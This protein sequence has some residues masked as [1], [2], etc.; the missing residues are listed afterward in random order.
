MDR[1]GK[2][3]KMLQEPS[4]V[5]LNLNFVAITS[6]SN[7]LQMIMMVKRRE[8]IARMATRRAEF[9]S[10]LLHLWWQRHVRMWD[11]SW[12]LNSSS[13]R[14]MWTNRSWLTLELL[15][16]CHFHAQILPLAYHNMQ[17]GQFAPRGKQIACFLAAVVHVINFRFRGAR[18]RR[19]LAATVR[20]L[21]TPNVL[22]VVPFHTNCWAGR[23]AVKILVELQFVK[24]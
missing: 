4:P 6:A 14:R 15:R 5:R 24:H 21:F 1:A 7:S 10:D 17:H 16:Q 12:L 22:V 23:N 13:L 18:V 8:T 3:R 11:G 2:W 19:P 20:V 9:T